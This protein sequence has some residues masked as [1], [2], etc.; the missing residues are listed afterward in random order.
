[1]GETTSQIETRIERTRED[2]GSN[3]RELENRVKT[4]ADWREHYR[5]NPLLWAGLAF[6]GG[7]FLGVLSRR[8]DPLE[9]MET[10]NAGVGGG[11][12]VNAGRARQKV[13]DSWEDIK[14]ALV[15]VATARVMDFLGEAVEGFDEHRK[16]SE[17]ERARPFQ[18]RSSGPRS[19]SSSGN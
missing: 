2:L 5:V 18:G 10:L 8:R 15:G 4:A 19:A 7:V 13:L 14:T 16:R 1:M 9:P 12:V 17:T 6:G 3:L 11:T